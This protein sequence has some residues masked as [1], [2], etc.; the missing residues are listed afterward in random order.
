MKTNFLSE[1][2]QQ[3]HLQQAESEIN[4]LF[5]TSNMLCLL[6]IKMWSRNFLSFLNFPLRKSQTWRTIALL[7]VSSDFMTSL[8]VAPSI[9]QSCTLR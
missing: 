2:Q 1:A 6:Y 8:I 5:E 4:V 9:F 7:I 3:F